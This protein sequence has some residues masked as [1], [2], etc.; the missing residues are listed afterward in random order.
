M[1]AEDVRHKSQ[2][3]L[4]SRLVE[5]QEQSAWYQHKHGAAVKR[6][7]QLKVLLLRCVAQPLH[8]CTHKVCVEPPSLTWLKS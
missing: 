7:D 2:Q 6:V 4:E 1:T 5:A 8:V 3:E